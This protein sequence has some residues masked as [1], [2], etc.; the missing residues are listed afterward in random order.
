MSAPFE[1]QILSAG[2]LSEHLRDQI[3]SLDTRVDWGQPPGVSSLVWAD[4]PP[5]VALVQVQG[6]LAAHVGIVEREILIGSR[7][8]RVGGISSVMT[9]PELQGRGYAT[10]ALHQATDFIRDRL[11][12]PFAL[13]TC[14]EHRRSFYERFG[15]VVLDQP[16]VCDQPA[17]KAL[18]T[19]PGRLMMSL[20][21]GAGA[22]PTGPVDLRGLPW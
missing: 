7:L 6:T 18:L 9:E 4:S 22:Q 11:S 21:F 13:L 2:D 12:V 15:W 20:S 1:V 16:V 10:A 17:G 8:L 19:C 5:W 14:L 3:R